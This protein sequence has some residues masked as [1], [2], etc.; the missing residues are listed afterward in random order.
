MKI[1][2]VRYSSPVEV[3]N[4]LCALCLSC[5]L[6]PNIQVT[7]QN[8]FFAHDSKMAVSCLHIRNGDRDG[9][10]GNT[11]THFVEGALLPPPF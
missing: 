1:K 4:S 3:K 9:Y 5:V 2:Q 8:T 6:K 7:T 10:G 11:A